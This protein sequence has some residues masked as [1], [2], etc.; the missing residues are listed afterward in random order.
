MVVHVVEEISSKLIS[1]FIP[2]KINLADRFGD[3]RG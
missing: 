2:K 1:L 3:G